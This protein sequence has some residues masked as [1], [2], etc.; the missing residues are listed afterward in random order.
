MSGACMYFMHSWKTFGEGRFFEGGC[1]FN[2]R[3]SGGALLR[4]WALFRGNTVAVAH[5]IQCVLLS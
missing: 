4:E 1:F 2:F 5:N 3:R